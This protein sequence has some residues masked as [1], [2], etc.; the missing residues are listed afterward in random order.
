MCKVSVFSII[1]NTQRK[2]NCELDAKSQL[3]NTY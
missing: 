1:D 2:I 3:F